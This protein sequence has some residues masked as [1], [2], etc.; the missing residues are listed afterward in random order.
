M[1]RILIILAVV[2]I[3]GALVAVRQITKG[4]GK[5]EQIA[6]NAVPV[7]TVAAGRGSVM[8]TCE[9]IGTV[10][11]D[12]TAQ[13]FPETIGRITQVLVREGSYVGKGSRLMG[14]RNET[15]GFE[16][17]EGFITAPI[18][19][20]VAN[21]MV[22]IGSMVTP[23]MPVATV[24]EFSRVEIAFNMSENAIGCIIKGNKVEI[25]AD[26]LSGQSFTG[27]VTEV[28]PVID[29]MS[30]TVSA[31]AMV[32]NPKKL[33]KPGMTARVIL[34]LDAKD[35]VLVI[36]RDVLLDG[37]LFVVKDSAAERRDVE[38]GLVGDERIEVISG[39]TEGEQ[40]VIIGQQRLAGGEKVNPIP[41]AQVVGAPQS[42]GSE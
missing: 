20:N 39:L 19:G 23:Q 2:I 29:P 36:P 35:N 38:I 15:I 21:I 9:I 33:L 31:K 5:E 42:S 37:F 27:T 22:D 24:V 8:S 25:V 11:A 40:V 30:R 32:N 10:R 18:S 28:S 1:R 4:K 17:E 12:K 3:L 41:R 16:Y 14:L 7:E 13:V 26:A 6:L 34:T